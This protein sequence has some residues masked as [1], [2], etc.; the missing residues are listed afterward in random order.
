[1]PEP[2][3]ALLGLGCLLTALVFAARRR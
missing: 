2:G 1:V 3:S